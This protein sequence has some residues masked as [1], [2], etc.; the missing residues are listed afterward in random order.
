M[1]LALAILERQ[2][3]LRGSTLTLRPMAA[4]D[5]EPLRAAASDPLIWAMHP[6]P[7]RWRRPVFE[8]FFA[9]GMASGGALVARTVHDDVVVGSSR[10][11]LGD[12][13]DLE[14]GWTFLARNLWGGGA[15][16]EMK[17]LMLGHAF[18]SVE[19][20]IFTIGAG[21]LRSRRA[22]EK[23]GAVHEASFVRERGETV[24]YRLRKAPWEAYA[25]TLAPF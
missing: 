14:I 13:G 16:L 17:R 7:D 10:F 18:A 22:V 4:E 24:R 11:H 9:E 8:R 5:F 12:S 19:A 21:N 2:P 23:L 15:N 6:E 3:V 20:V 1:V 25:A